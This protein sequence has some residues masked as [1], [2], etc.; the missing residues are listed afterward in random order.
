MKHTITGIRKFM[1]GLF[2]MSLLSFCPTGAFAAPDGGISINVKDRSITWV[3]EQLNKDFS[4]NFVLL[5]PEINVDR[6][7]SVNLTDA[8]LSEVMKAIFRDGDVSWEVMGNTVRIMKKENS[9]ASSLSGQNVSGKIT[10]GEGEPLVGAYILEKGTSN[11]A[12]ADLDGNYSIALEGSPEDAILT[13]S[14]VGYLTRD[15]QVSAM[16]NI[17]VALEEDT[18]MLEGVVVMGYGVQRKGDITGAVSTVQ[19]RSIEDIPVNNFGAAIAGRT[20]GVQVVSPSGKPSGGFS[21]RVRGA[22]SITAG[23]EPLYVVDGVP[24]TDTYSINPEEIESIT[25]LKDASSAAIYGS[26][27]ANGVVLITTK[28]GN[29]EETTVEF[30]AYFGFSSRPKKIDVLNADEYQELLTDLGYG[31]IDKSVYNAD[32]DWQDEMFQVAPVQNYHLSISGGSEKTKYY[33]AGGYTDQDGIIKPSSFGRMNFKVNFEYQAKSWLKVGTTLNYSR[34]KEV[35]ISDGTSESVVLQSITTPSVVGKY[36]SDGTFMTLPFLSS[37]E[38]PLSG[39]ENYDRNKVTNRLLGYFFAEITLWKDLK[40]KTSLGWEAGSSRYK[41]FLDPFN[42]IWGRNQEGMA[43]YNTS[44]DY[45]WINENIFSWSHVYGR[46]SVS[47]LAGFIV[48]KNVY[49][50]A[51][52]SVQG[53]SSNKLHI[54]NAGT[55]FNQPTEYYGAA[56]N[57]SALARINYDYDNRFMATVNFRADGSSKFGADN[58]WGF[59]PSFSAGWRISNESFMRNA[60]WL[61]DLKIRVGWGMTGNDQIGNYSS[62]SIYGTGAN[63]NIDGSIL[64]GYYQSQIGNDKLKWET[65]S[66]TN[67]GID[68]SVLDSRINFNLDLYHK[69]TSDLLLMVNLP[70]STGF[71]SGIQNVGKVVNKG[72]ELQLSTRNLTGGFKWNTDFNISFNDNKVLDMASSP[73]IYT[74]AL[75]KKIAGNVSII[76]EGLPLGTFWGYEA[77]GVNP[78]TGRMMYENADGML[79]YEEDLDPDTDRRDIGCAQPLFTY[80]IGNDFRWKNLSLSILLQGSFGN[81]IFNATRMFTEGMFDSRNQS[82]AVLMRWR[83]PGDYTTIPKPE[84]DNYPVISSRFVEDGSYLKIRNIRLGYSF[85]ERWINKIRLKTLSVY[86]SADN[87]VTWTNYSG[88]DPEV[89]ISGTSATAM[90]IDQGVFPH[91]RTYV[92]G[93]N[94]VF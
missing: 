29:R 32:I 88:L 73:V 17:N 34:I 57:A 31:Q 8:T 70:L 28:S 93:V 75:D 46:H 19:A 48:S 40:F 51:D 50:G 43:R 87:L 24:T 62:Y 58:R 26:A 47:A 77:V 68:M 9:R 85:P 45:K 53:F 84:K 92:F 11:G 82:S 55:V 72:I 38:N 4:L 10:D 7:V 42:S 52:V 90:S 79:V 66:Q 35:D 74:G 64:S 16:E 1:A 20:A 3:L 60:M 71:E 39:I 89:N 61:N 91:P 81:E 25:V 30:N 21:V 44:F 54:L 2:L 49:E 63:Y 36:S 65:T 67:V 37:L 22:T 12:I 23:N 27:G 5:T 59:F 15:V 56:S 86:V 80:G 83:Q 69:Y 76:K 14:Y 94:V 41:E 6:K 78:D 33:I 13:F 18:Q